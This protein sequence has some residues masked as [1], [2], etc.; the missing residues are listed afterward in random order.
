MTKKQKGKFM[1]AQVMPQ[2]AALLGLEEFNPK[3][4]KTGTFGCS[5]CHTT[6]KP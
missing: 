6:A 4:P 5:N 2:M 1:K 3:E